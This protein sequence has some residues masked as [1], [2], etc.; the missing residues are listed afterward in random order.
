MSYTY[1]TILKETNK[2]LPSTKQK[3]KIAP[4]IFKIS[5]ILNFFFHN[6]QEKTSFIKK[7]TSFIKKKIKIIFKY[8]FNITRISSRLIILFVPYII[9]SLSSASSLRNYSLYSLLSVTISFSE[10]NLTKFQS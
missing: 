5:M 9:C 2:K 8:F 3:K 1:K 7:I 10:V 6:H 4:P